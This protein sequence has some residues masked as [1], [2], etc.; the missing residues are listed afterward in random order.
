QDGR[1]REFAQL[2]CD[3][4]GD[5]S[6]AG[7][8]EMIALAID[9][10]RTFGLT[11]SD[12]FIRIN[13]RRVWEQFLAERG[14]APERTEEFLQV[15]D[16]LEREPE[17]V[18]AARCE[19]LGVKIA[20]VRD[21]LKKPAPLLEPLAAELRGRGLQDYVRFDASV[22]RGLAYYTGVVFEVFSPAHGRALAGG[23]R[24]DDLLSTLSDGRVDMAA[25]GFAIGDVVTEKVLR[26]TP[27]AAQR[28][29]AAVQ[30]ESAPQ[31]F[32]VVADEE[33]RL[34]AVSLFSALRCAGMRVD[35]PLAAM[36]VGKQ[37]QLA[38]QAA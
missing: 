31:I 5:R 18:N 12:F 25:M 27:H 20:D 16:K 3:L 9:L 23:G 30:A 28:L 8:A 32:G 6:V 36:K 14:F 19:A 33:H 10:F 35:Y 4:F 7:E 37:F 13:D 29:E 2:N 26:A 22:V 17:E 21:F 15:I 34:E 11:A 24:Y 1:L 38:E